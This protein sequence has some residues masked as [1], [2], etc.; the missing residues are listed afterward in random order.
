M[1]HWKEAQQGRKHPLDREK[2]PAPSLANTTDGA[3]P[4]PPGGRTAAIRLVSGRGGGQKGI[5]S[6]AGDHGPSKHDG[7]GT[8]HQLTSSWPVQDVGGR[9]LLLSFQETGGEH[10]QGHGQ[11][12]SMWTQGPPLSFQEMG[13]GQGRGCSGERGERRNHVQADGQTDNTQRHGHPDHTH[14][15][16]LPPN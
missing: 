15:G 11:R 13:W 7:N 10:A 8:V 14:W 9:P 1:A 16:N 2:T 5:V 12:D 4:P 6:L 3:A